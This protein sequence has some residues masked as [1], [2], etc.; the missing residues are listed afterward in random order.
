[1]EREPTKRLG[2]HHTGQVK[3]TSDPSL[4]ME[5]SEKNWVIQMMVLGK[6]FL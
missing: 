2:A 1:M 5:N 4:F 3:D 6:E